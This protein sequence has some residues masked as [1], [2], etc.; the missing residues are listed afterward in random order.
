MSCIVCPSSIVLLGDYKMHWK[1]KKIHSKKQTEKL[2]I[3]KL[4]SE[5]DIVVYNSVVFVLPPVSK[6]C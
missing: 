4:K 3:Q 6:T 2:F 1:L 5:Y